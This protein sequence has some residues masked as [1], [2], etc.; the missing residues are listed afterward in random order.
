MT[1]S[2][3]HRVWEVLIVL[4]GVAV[5]FFI[6]ATVPEATIQRDAG[7]AVLALVTLVAAVLVWEGRDYISRMRLRWPFVLQT[8]NGMGRTG[9]SDGAATVKESDRGDRELAD[10]R[11][12][13]AALMA[14]PTE[15]TPE[16][17]HKA[18]L[19]SANFKLTAPERSLF[20]T[21][22][23]L[24]LTGSDLDYD[25]QMVPDIPG[26]PTR[27]GSVHYEL[28]CWDKNAYPKKQLMGVIAAQE[29]D[30]LLR[31]AAAHR[32]MVAQLKTRD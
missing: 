29:R 8:E 21:W 3:M 23:G 28:R 9:K 15:W 6:S 4:L 18:A 14:T 2:P 26:Q 24:A 12:E 11:V 19:M 32:T 13:V 22:A 30:E 1:A 17:R 10:L 27:V 7:V 16:I 25:V 5:S 20:V 31:L